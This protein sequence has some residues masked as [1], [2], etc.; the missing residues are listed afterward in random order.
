MVATSDKKDTSKTWIDFPLHLKTSCKTITWDKLILNDVA[1]DM[2]LHDSIISILQFYTNTQNGTLN[3]TG[4]MLKSSSSLPFNY[5]I[6]FKKLDI[7]DGD[8]DFF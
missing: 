7:E 2:I 1:A 3:A 4:N 6:D 5:I 8:I